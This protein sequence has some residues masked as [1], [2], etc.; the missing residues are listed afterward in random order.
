[1]TGF[2]ES[3]ILL[4]SP[5]LSV[6]SALPFAC[7]FYAQPAITIVSKS[8]KPD[9]MSLVLLGILMPIASKLP[10]CRAQTSLQTQNR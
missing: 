3:K 9:V 1:M 4:N 7:G 8:D 5:G 2:G 10:E 6:L